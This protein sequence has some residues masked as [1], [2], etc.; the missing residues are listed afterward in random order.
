MRPEKQRGRTRHAS[1]LGERN[2]P[3]NYAQ[4]QNDGGNKQLQRQKKMQIPFRNDRKKSN[5]GFLP[6][7]PR[8]VCGTK[9][10]GY[11][12]VTVRLYVAEWVRNPSVAVTV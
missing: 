9:K 5:S 2:T 6:L 7:R 11:F 8:S 1:G 12:A 10:A 4:G 3:I